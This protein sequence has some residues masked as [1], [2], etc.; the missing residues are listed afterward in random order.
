MQAFILDIRI[1]Q[2]RDKGDNKKNDECDATLGKHICFILRK[3]TSKNDEKTHRPSK[4]I[5]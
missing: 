3:N 2:Y 4:K 1:N 5:S